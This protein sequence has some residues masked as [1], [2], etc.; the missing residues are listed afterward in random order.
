MNHRIGDDECHL[1]LVRHG[2]TPNNLARPQRLQ[3]RGMDVA[4]ADEGHR[5][6][7]QLAKHFAQKAIDRVYSSPL[8]RA[9]QT[10]ETIAL[11][12][13]LSVELIDDLTESDVG[14][15]EGL[16]W[17]EVEA[18]Y[19]E[20]YR[21]YMEDPGANPYYG[22]ESFADVQQRVVPVLD[23]LLAENLGRTIVVVA[24]N[25]VN[26][27]L[28]AHLIDLPISRVHKLPQ[29]NGASNFIRYRKGKAELVTMN[30]LGHLE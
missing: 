26:R 20:A 5:E 27:S 30:W 9:R 28:I 7:E 10:A 8:L 15:W 16:L 11:A 29:K 21:L 22:G 24:H 6:A 13:D 4:L 12:H 18:Q 3:G 19:P 23:E 1:H 25:S 14:H 2:S 17:N